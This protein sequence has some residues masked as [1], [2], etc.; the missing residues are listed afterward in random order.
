MEQD[1]AIAEGEPVAIAHMR[2]VPKFP[3]AS[4]ST[5]VKSNTEYP[6]F[7]WNGDRLSK[8]GWSS[9]DAR[10]YEQRAPREAVEEIC[11]QF[12]EKSGPKK[13]LKLEKMLPMKSDSGDEIPSY[14]VY[15]VLKWL[16]SLGVVSRQ[17]KD[18]YEVAKTWFDVRTL[19]EETPSR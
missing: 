7:V 18:G 9:K 1:E 5:Q 16:Q 8:L 6:R 13:L 12:I 4:A 3:R 10:I 14:Q 19:F 11:Q 15:L 2:P 17:G